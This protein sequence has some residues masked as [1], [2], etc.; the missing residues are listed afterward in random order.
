M[1]GILL[2]VLF[3]IVLA[4]VTVGY[5]RNRRGELSPAA[6]ALLVLL[7]SGNFSL[8]F[9]HPHPGAVSRRELSH[10]RHPD[11]ACCYRQLEDGLLS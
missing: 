2:I 3:V 7:L 8:S 5:E 1:P 10:W 6:G 9:Q 4:S 11:R